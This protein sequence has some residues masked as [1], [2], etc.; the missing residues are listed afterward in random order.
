ML[1]GWAVPVKASGSM[2]T[3]SIVSSFSPKAKISSTS[4]AL[5]VW[6]LKGITKQR[7]SSIGTLIIDCWACATIWTLRPQVHIILNNLNVKRTW[8]LVCSFGNQKGNRWSQ[9]H[10]CC[11]RWQEA[12]STSSRRLWST[13]WRSRPRQTC[14]QCCRKY[15]GVVS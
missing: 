6:D 15:V 13:R 11:D 5:Y 4:L 7:Y 8:T 1:L 12:A 10:R 9:W 3:H 2:S 14:H